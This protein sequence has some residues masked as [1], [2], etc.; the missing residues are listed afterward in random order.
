MSEFDYTS[1]IL[2][3]FRV[4]INGICYCS[5]LLPQH[6]LPAIRQVSG[7]VQKQCPSIQVMLVF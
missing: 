3:D 4:K 1:L 2:L 6:L 5:L 7:R